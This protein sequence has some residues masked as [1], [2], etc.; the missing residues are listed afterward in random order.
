MVLQQFRLARNFV[1][2]QGD[3]AE[4]Y[5]QSQLSNQIAGMAVR[6]ARHSLLLDPTGKLVAALRVTRFEDTVFVLDV[7]PGFVA[8]AQPRRQDERVLRHRDEVELAGDGEL[9]PHIFPDVRRVAVRDELQPRT[10][11]AGRDGTHG[12]LA[13]A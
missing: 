6:T 2:V 13:V 9:V 7:E 12:R 5:L 3:D 8:V 10:R 1:C 11:H 4:S